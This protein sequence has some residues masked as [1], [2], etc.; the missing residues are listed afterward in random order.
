MRKNL[1]LFDIDGTL[2]NINK[3]HLASYKLDYKETAGKNV[4]DGTIL[5]TF[6]MSESDAHK[7]IFQKLGIPYDTS[8]ITKIMSSHIPN[9]KKIL[10]QTDIIPLEGAISFLE[11]LKKRRQYTGIVTGNLEEIAKLILHKSSLIKSFSA[12]NCDDGKSSRIQILKRAINSA[13][14]RKYKFK[15]IIV[16]GDT[17]KDIEAG[18]YVKALTVAVATG[19]DS[20]KKLKKLKPD[21]MLK[22]LKDYRLIFKELGKDLSS[23]HQQ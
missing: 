8:L 22:S 6:G 20:I 14:R 12:L 19:S 13:K 18:K 15:K 16:I 1:W 17:T 2:V 11:Y 9:F 4:S 5:S 3:I 10:N 23:F 21:I 7:K